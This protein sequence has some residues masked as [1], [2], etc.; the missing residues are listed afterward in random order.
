MSTYAG[1]LDHNVECHTWML[2]P[3][4]WARYGDWPDIAACRAPMPLL[5]QY[6][7]WDNLFS[8]EGMQAAH[9]RLHNHYAT[10]GQ[11]NRYTGQFHDNP[12]VFD[13]AMQ[14]AAFAWLQAEL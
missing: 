12:H 10:V 3:H 9:E 14:Q 7:R 1:L 11:P 2:F 4:G 6:D 8:P 13:L 5:V